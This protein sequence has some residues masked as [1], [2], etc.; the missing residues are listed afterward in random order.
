MFEYKLQVTNLSI[1]TFHEIYVLIYLTLSKNAYTCFEEF[2]FYV[3]ISLLD[4][5]TR[6]NMH[7]KNGAVLTHYTVGVT[8]FTIKKFQ[9]LFTPLS[10]IASPDIVSSNKHPRYLTLEC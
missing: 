3:L 8:I 5:D 7:N 9:I 4:L 1:Q 6:Q 10:A 2:E